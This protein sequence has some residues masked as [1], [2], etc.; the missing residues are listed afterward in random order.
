MATFHGYSLRKALVVLLV[1]AMSGCGLLPSS[2]SDIQLIVV[3]N[4]D[5]PATFRFVEY[6]FEAGEAGAEIAPSGE[7][8]W[9]GGSAEFG[10]VI[11]D[12]ESW[13]YLINDI[14]AVTS[15]EVQDLNRTMP[16]QGPLVF[17][18]SV[19]EG[20]LE[21]SPSRGGGGAGVTA[22]PIPPP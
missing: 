20:A 2:G 14:P 21:I 22:E 11:P 15:F 6:D 19:K 9:A 7:P 3:N 4:T 17:H 10:V 13:A 12:V 5:A 8:L 16:G 18:I 1:A